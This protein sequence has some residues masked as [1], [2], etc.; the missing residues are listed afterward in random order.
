MMAYLDWNREEDK[1]IDA[2]VAREGDEPG[3]RGVGAIWRRVER[4]I[5]EQQLIYS[6]K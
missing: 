4:D 1:R 2:Q 5:E 3:R 6:K